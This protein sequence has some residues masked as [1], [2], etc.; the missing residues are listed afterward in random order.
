MY[1]IRGLQCI[2]TDTTTQC[3][4]TH[5]KSSHT[6]SVSNK[7][8]NEVTF[9]YKYV[10]LISKIAMESFLVYCKIEMPTFVQFTLCSNLFSKYE[11]NCIKVGIAF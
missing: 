7:F 3:L 8:S 9:F 11:N 6:Q 10:F 4:K 2:C 1:P 5:Q